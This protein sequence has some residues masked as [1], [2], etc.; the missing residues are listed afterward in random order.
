MSTASDHVCC[1]KQYEAAK[2]DDVEPMD[3]L[4]AWLPTHIPPGDDTCIAHGDFRLENSIY[5]PIEPRMIAVLDWE[6]STLGHPFADL[7]YNCMLYH[8]NSPTQG[9][10]MNL[11]Y[12]AV[13]IPSESDYVG[14]YCRRTD[15]P[16]VDHWEFYV[17]FALFRLASIAQGVYKRGLDGNAS[18]HVRRRV[19]V[20][21]DDR[22]GDSCAERVSAVSHRV[23]LR[24]TVRGP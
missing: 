8:V 20:S 3:N 24:Y 11:D 18:E 7:A 2:T 4:I 19:G 12:A 5:H 23:A 14:A 13:G 9:T 16:G 15:R 22:V 6:L 1:T 21:V 10:L 17:A